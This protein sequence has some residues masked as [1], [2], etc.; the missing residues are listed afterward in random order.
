MEK[1]CNMNNERNVFQ[2]KA[3]NGSGRRRFSQNSCSTRAVATIY[4]EM[5]MNRKK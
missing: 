4:Y 1:P 3:E 2:R 5:N